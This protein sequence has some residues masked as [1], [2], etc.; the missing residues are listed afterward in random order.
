MLWLTERF[1]INTHIE[2]TVVLVVHNR[3]LQSSVDNTS[4]DMKVSVDNTS[5][6]MKV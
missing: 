3:T 5:L 1:V 6:D 4:S 2:S